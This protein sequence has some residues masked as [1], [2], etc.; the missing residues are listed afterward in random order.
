[1]W[2]VYE[3]DQCISESFK[4]T[5]NFPPQLNDVLSI[6]ESKWQQEILDISN[7]GKVTN[8]VATTWPC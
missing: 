2:K 6:I 5:N 3:N 4:E 7:V 8:K 1:M